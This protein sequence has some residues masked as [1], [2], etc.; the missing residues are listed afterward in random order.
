MS[1]SMLVALF[2]KRYD[3]KLIETIITMLVKFLVTY[4]RRASPRFGRFSQ[5]N[6][7]EDNK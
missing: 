5:R 7:K 3:S 6:T 4:E 2:I 1:I